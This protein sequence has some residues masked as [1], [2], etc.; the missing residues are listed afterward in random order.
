MRLL[1]SL[2]LGG[3][4]RGLPVAEREAEAQHENPSQ[5]SATRTG[6]PSALDHK[7]NTG[8]LQIKQCFSTAPWKKQAKDEI[9]ASVFI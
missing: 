8:I 4:A 2:K 6:S 7:L 9:I 3:L 1:P 5:E